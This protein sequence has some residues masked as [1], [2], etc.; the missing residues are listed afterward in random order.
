MCSCHVS[1]WLMGMSSSRPTT[2]T[3]LPG[4]LCQCLGIIIACPGSVRSIT[5]H[6]GAS[7]RNGRYRALLMKEGAPHQ[8]TDD[9]T[10]AAHASQSDLQRVRQNMY[11]II[12]VPCEGGVMQIR[13]RSGMADAD[14]Q[15]CER[16]AQSTGL[17]LTVVG[18]TH[19]SCWSSDV[20]SWQLKLQE[21]ALWL[22]VR[23]GQ[24]HFL[25]MPMPAR[26]A[27]C[28]LLQTSGAI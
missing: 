20:L 7:V 8:I 2:L 24:W 14:A 23:D 9:H 17:R 10:P 6:F 22:P 16:S 18:K 11:V 26:D 28:V 12:C 1:A 27:V 5:V 3:P 19:A 13:A 21:F 4:C 15:K 25:Q